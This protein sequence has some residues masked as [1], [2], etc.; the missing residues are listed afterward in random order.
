MKPTIATQRLY[1]HWI[2]LSIPLTLYPPLPLT[3]KQSR[4]QWDRLVREE[5]VPLLGDCQHYPKLGHSLRFYLYL[6]P[7]L[8]KPCMSHSHRPRA[9]TLTHLHSISNKVKPPRPSTQ[10]Q[11]HPWTFFAQCSLDNCRPM[12]SSE[13]TLGKTLG[14]GDRQSLCPSVIQHLSAQR[15]ALFCYCTLAI[16]LL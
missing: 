11:S 7:L 16:P 10:L 4:T 6:S 12:A 15:T 14:H 8:C 13:A 2:P 5:D 3:A 9:H 1:A